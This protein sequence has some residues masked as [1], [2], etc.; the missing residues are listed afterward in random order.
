MQWWVRVSAHC[1]LGLRALSQVQFSACTYRALTG[2]RH[3][4]VVAVGQFRFLC[5][6]STKSLTAI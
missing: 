3:H 4:S 2:R 5:C 1:S 6:T